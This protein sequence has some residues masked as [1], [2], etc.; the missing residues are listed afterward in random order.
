MNLRQGLAKNWENGVLV[1]LLAVLLAGCANAPPQPPTAAPAQGSASQAAPAGAIPWDWPAST[2]EQ[3]GI[4]SAG[5]AEAIQRVREQGPRLASLLILRNGI[6]V[7]EA[8][9]APVRQDSKHAVFSCTKSVVSALIGIAIQQGS[10]PGVQVRI[11]EPYFPDKALANPDPAKED[12]T[13]ENVLTMTSGLGWVESDPSFGQLY[14]SPDWAQFMLDLPMANTPGST[15]DYCSGCSHLLSVILEQATGMGTL[16]FAR[17]NLFEPLGIS[18]FSWETDRQGRPIGGWGLHMLPRDM[19]KLGQL[20]LQGGLWEGR[21]VV[22]AEWVQTSV[23][24]H[25]GADGGLGYGYQWW[26]DSRIQGFVALGVGGQTILVIPDQE[27]VIV[28]TA[29]GESYDTTFPMIEK[30]ILPAISSNS[31]LDPDPA[32]LAA[33]QAQIQ[34]AA[35]GE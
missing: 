10:I 3:Q 22:P 23:S 24:E 1:L 5:L 19:A 8:Y 9:F 25:I 15:F 31:P 32:G 13:L 16:D 18:D 33:L 12:I 7:A 34:A 20:Y 28:T 35:G 11:L 21:Q 17:Q 30:S 14:N 4:R 26:S 6:L 29:S 27:L 2:P